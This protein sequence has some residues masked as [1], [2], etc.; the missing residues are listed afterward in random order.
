MGFRQ[1]FR[2]VFSKEMRELL[3]DRRALF[4]LLAPP[5]ILPA[6]AILGAVFIGVQA[7]GQLTRGFPVA[8]VHP[9]AAPELVAMLASSR[10]LELVDPP[11]AEGWGRA[12]VVLTVP[13]DFTERVEAEA[14]VAVTLTTRDATWTTGLAAASVRGMLQRYSD[15]LLDRRLESRG[16]N[17]AWLSPVVVGEEQAPTEGLVRAVTLEGGGAEGRANPLSALF[18]PLAVTSWLVGGGLGLIVDTTV[19]EKER[20]TMEALL[21]TPASRLGIVAGK[22]A[23]VFI[24]S[25]VVMSLWLAEG[26]LLSVLVGAAPALLAVQEGAMSAGDVIL[27]SAGQVLQLVFYLVLLILPFIVILNSLVMAWCTFASTYRESNLMLFVIQLALP[28]LVIVS[29]FSL[30]ADAGLGWYLTPLL[31]TIVAIRDLFS[32]V[33][34]PLDLVIAVLSA[35][36]YAALALAL[37]AYVFSREWALVRGI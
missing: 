15:L 26:V 18:L 17:R 34:A 24:A 9:K 16:L 5:F 29:V 35:A 25:M 6:I 10:S 22:L 4:F 2:T 32:G 8:V 30:P 7:I 21:L 12:L 3:R 19:G 1:A 28:A 14:P 11:G 23:V 37:S 27:S 33:L 20:R 13:E 36:V 31:G